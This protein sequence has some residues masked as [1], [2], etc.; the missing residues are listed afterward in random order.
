MQN[1]ITVSLVQPNFRQGGD[2]HPQYWLPHSAACVYV[3]VAEQLR[4]RDLLRINEIVFRR[5]HTDQLAP[6]LAKDNL[7]LFSN[8]MWNWEYNLTLARKIKHLNPQCNII[9]GGPQVSEHR[10]EQQQAQY[11]FVDTW[12]VSEGELSFESYIIDYLNSAVNNICALF[13]ILSSPFPKHLGPRSYSPR[14]V[15]HSS[16]CV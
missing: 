11:P 13:P 6:R 14:E 12:I 15:R 7:V 5:E 8:Y 2:T 16:R 4:F 1:K 9:F 3:Y 10:L